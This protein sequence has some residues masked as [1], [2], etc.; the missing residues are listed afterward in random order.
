LYNL[1][2]KWLCSGMGMCR[3]LVEER[4]IKL[5]GNGYYFRTRKR[6]FL[7]MGSSMNITLCRKELSHLCRDMSSFL[8]KE[9][10]L[11]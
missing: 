9:M 3:R 4:G 8:C 6:R 5:D 1:S 2:G 10:V 11:F 7:G